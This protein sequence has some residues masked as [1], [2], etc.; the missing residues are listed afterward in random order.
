MSRLKIAVICI[1]DELLKGFTVNTNLTD[2]GK[3]LLQYGLIIDHATVISDTKEGIQ[4]ELKDMLRKGSNIVI[5]TGGLGPTVDDLTK[6]AVAEI[7]NLKLINSEEVADKLKTYWS[8]RTTDMPPSVMNQTLIPE[9]ASILPNSVGTAP[10][11]LIK[12]GQRETGKAYT[13][14]EPPS[15]ILLPGPPSELNPMLKDHVIPFITSISG[16]DRLYTKTIYTSGLPESRIEEKTLPLINRSDFNIA[17]CASPAAVKIYLSGRDPILL[18]KKEKELRQSLGKYALPKDTENPVQFIVNYCIENS[19]TISTAE[20]CTGGLIA[21]AITDIPGASEVFRGSVVSYSNEWKNQILKV[22]EKTI[23]EF[24]AVSR[25]CASEMVSNLCSLYKTDM[26]ISVT[27]IA[28]PGGGTPEKPVG[29]V[30][31]GVEINGKKLIKQFNFRGNRTKIRQRTLYSACNFLRT[32]ID[33][34]THCE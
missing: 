19:L 18:E 12:P 14:S 15:I 25:E 26:G 1:G 27:G 31:I 24:G 6:S 23:D 34:Q 17:Y 28:G 13:E 3:E 20:S 8:G 5:L 9:G 21:A 32:V 29:L 16:A 10:G 30:Y 33:Q 2:I 4:A 11:L 22:S 7:F